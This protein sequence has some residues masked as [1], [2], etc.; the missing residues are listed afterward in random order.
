MRANR[1][2]RGNSERTNRYG[3]CDARGY[4]HRPR[5]ATSLDGEMDAED[6]ETEQPRGDAPPFYAG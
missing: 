4:A 1:T 2:K 6:Q 3:E 5:V